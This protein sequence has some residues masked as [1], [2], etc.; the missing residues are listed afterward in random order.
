M[1]KCPA[2][3]LLIVPLLGFSFPGAAQ[4]S[5]QNPQSPQSPA[6]KPPTEKLEEKQ[7]LEKKALALLNEIVAEAMGL[8]SPESRI[9]VLSFAGQVLWNQEQTRARGYYREAINQ[10]LAI[11]P[12]PQAQ[13]A[14]P[15]R[16]NEASQ[17]RQALRS[18]L[19]QTIGEHDPQMA[20]EFLRAS[21]SPA[22]V[23]KKGS[24]VEDALQ[25]YENQMELQLASQI[26]ENDPK[27]ALQLAEESLKKGMNSQIAEIWRRLM[28]KDPAAAAR[29]SE[30]I[31]ARIRSSDLLKDYAAGSSLSELAYGLRGRIEAEKERKKEK[32]ASAPAGL[33]LQDLERT[34]RDLLETLVSTVLKI[35]PADLMNIAEQGPA[36]GLLSQAQSFLPDVEKYLPS[37]FTQLKGKLAQYDKAFYHP[38]A[39]AENFEE[40][41]KKTTAELMAMAEKAKDESREVLY[42]QAMAKAMAEGDVDTAKQISSQH[43]KRSEEFMDREFDRIERTKAIKDGDLEGARKSIDQ[44]PSLADRAVAIIQMSDSLK[45]DVKQRELLDE[46]KAL[47]GAKLETR[48][49]VDAQLALAIAY[50][51]FDPEYSFSLLDAAVESLNAVTAA[52]LMLMRFN[53][54]IT[55]EEDDMGQIGLP[56]SPLWFMSGLESRILAFAHKDFSRT[57]S[58]IA[59]WQ[60]AQSRLSLNL[61]LVRMIFNDQLHETPFRIVPGFR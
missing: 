42:S 45:D 15:I 40:L 30:A 34:F 17:M 46:A 47:L 4:Q 11:S 44:I 21:R 23:E 36:R 16:P 33:S 60:H 12:A 57:Q 31:V 55:A 61:A 13:G 24:D 52:S 26:A 19:V 28:Q 14:G 49:Q 41:E 50:L 48:S 6:E 38:P 3:I 9:Q 32:S 58:S 18:Q 10:F 54:E 25:G 5:P 29:L 53:Q 37:R 56:G 2:T 7:E 8:R 35:T 1:F 39:F 59:R 20:L 43:L 22:P 51:K 27:S